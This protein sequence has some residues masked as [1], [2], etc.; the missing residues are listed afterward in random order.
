MYP[1]IKETARLYTL[2]SDR[3]GSDVAEAIVKYIDNKTERSVEAATQIMASKEDLSRHIGEVQKEIIES[4]ADTI[5][6]MFIFWVGQ[7][8]S[9]LAMAILFLKR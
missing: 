8:G 3:L 1:G 4:K 9:M 2:L 7:I 6:W 5:K